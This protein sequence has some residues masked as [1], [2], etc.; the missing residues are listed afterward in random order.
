MWSSTGFND[1]MAGGFNNT[2]T[3]SD[4][5]SKKAGAVKRHQSV[6]PVVIRMLNDCTEDEFKMFGLPVQMVS[7]VGILINYEV[8]STNASYTIE[9]HTGTLKA[10][11][12]LDSDGDD[13]TTQ[14]PS[15]KEGSY[16]KAFGTIKTQEDRRTLMI[17]NMLPVDDCN[18]ITLH[19]LE[20]IKSRL[21][22]EDLSNAA[23]FQ[24][25]K[26]NPGA[27]LANTMIMMDENGA[28]N[29]PLNMSE[30]QKQVFRLLQADN[31]AAG[32]DRDSILNKFSDTRKREASEALD[33]MVNEGHVYT[34]IDN[35]HFKI[36]EAI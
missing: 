3:N 15:V 1:S 27:E 11:W 33:F 29:A 16:V 32:P 8:Q 10:M 20:V 36:T 35:E 28:S 18:V 22:A 26:N 4:S 31:T 6:V 5:P 17:L 2:T 12:W 13:G 24:I 19:L 34:T 14:L 25:Q 7:V 30:I 21:Q 9:D 23:A